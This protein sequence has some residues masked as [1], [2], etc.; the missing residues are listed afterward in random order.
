M[1]TNTRKAI[2]CKVRNI[3]SD[4]SSLTWNSSLKATTPL[5]SFLL[6]WI[7]SMSRKKRRAARTKRIQTRIQR[8]RAVRPVASEGVASSTE[9]NRLTK[10]SRVVIRRPDLRE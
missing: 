1:I 3:L 7:P 6:L 8:A 5:V 9:L 2:T 10:T 4:L